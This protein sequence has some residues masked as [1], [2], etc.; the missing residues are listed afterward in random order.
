MTSLKLCRRSIDAAC[1]VSAA[2]RP[3]GLL[4]D[5]SWFFGRRHQSLGRG[6]NFPCLVILP[7]NGRGAKSCSSRRTHRSR[8]LLPAECCEFYICN[9][10]SLIA[11]DY[12]ISLTRVREK[13]PISGT[14]PRRQTNALGAC[15]STVCTFIGD[16]SVELFISTLL[17]F[18]S[19]C[20]LDGSPSLLAAE[21]AIFYM[22]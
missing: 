8:S 1:L 21:G 19:R 10:T 6:R 20:R 11:D 7:K 14:T 16:R 22:S 12:Y 9:K 17:T 4:G 13:K 2:E 3:S 5:R 18:C 15:E